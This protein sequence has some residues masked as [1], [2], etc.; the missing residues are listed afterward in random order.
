MDELTRRVVSYQQSGE[1][2]AD[3]VRDLSA[4]TYQFPLRNRRCTEDDCGEFLLFVAARIS[5]MVHRYD[6]RGVAFEAYLHTNLKWLLR[7]YLKRRDRRLREARLAYR[8]A[9]WHD[10]NSEVVDVGPLY[11]QGRRPGEVG[12]DDVDRATPVR[13]PLPFGPWFNRVQTVGH[14]RRRVMIIALKAC[15]YLSESDIA[16]VADLTGF[17][18][19]WLCESWLR[20]RARLNCRRHGYDVL[21]LRRN[22]LFVRLQS[23]H[24][25]LYACCD[26]AE[27]LRLL[28]ENAVMRQRLTRLRLKISRIPR[29]PTNQEIAEVTGIPKGTIDSALYYAKRKLF[30]VK[31]PVAGRPK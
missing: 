15:L 13:D 27:R 5:G 12:C 10:T 22:R 1:G 23:S 3:L 2:L 9:L 25:R 26:H 8:A 16:M 6:F 24:D 30:P 11:D 28:H 14:S 4:A 17:E 19:E 20:L 29:C 18:R 31:K 7:T 21:R